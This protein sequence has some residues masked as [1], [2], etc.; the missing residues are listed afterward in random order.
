M[1]E[2]SFKDNEF[3]KAAYQATTKPFVWKKIKEMNDNFN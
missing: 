1:F 2:R 3:I